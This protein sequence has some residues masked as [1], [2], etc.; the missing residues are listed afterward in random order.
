MNSRTLKW[1]ALI[2]MVIDHVGHFLLPDLFLLRVIGRLA[3]PIFTFLFANS[4]RFTSNRLKLGIRVWLAA[5]IGQAIMVFFGAGEIISIF[6]L[7]G[8]ALILFELIDRGFD[9]AFILIALTAE[10]FGVDYGAYGIIVLYFFY[11]FHDQFTKQALA[12][13]II[14]VFFV[15]YPFMIPGNWSYIP[16]IINQFWTIGWH[17]LVQGFSM[18]SLVLLAFY[19]SDK[20]K[21]FPQPF[22]SI[23]KWFFYIFYPLH[24]A[25][26]AF[27]RG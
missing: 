26:L 1:I 20:P 10:M 18:L 9:W 25:L 17:Y 11:K 3:F 22:Q 15:F 16:L 2:T 6:F 13:S 27:L 14:T 21:A 23:E 8:L 7:F 24:I 4:A 5:F 19:Q 12:Y